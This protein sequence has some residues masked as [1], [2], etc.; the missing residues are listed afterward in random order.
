MTT[1]QDLIADTRRMAYGTLNEQINLVATEYTAGAAT[2]VMDMDV[3]NITPGMILSGGLN[4]WYVK[5]I[6]AGTKTVY[7]IPKFDNSPEA[8]LPV[9]TFVYI[10]PR[11]TDWNLFS[12]INEEILRMSSPENGLYKIASWTANVDSTWQTYSIPSTAQDMI[13]LVRVRYRVPGSDDTWVDIPEKTYRMQMNVDTFYIRLLRNIPSGTDI[14]FIY[15]SPFTPAT[16]VDDDVVADCGLTPSMVDIPPLGA[17]ASLMRTTESRRNQVQMQG[18]A[19]RAQEVVSGANVN[20][21]ARVERDYKTR[22]NEELA[23]L[24]QRNSIQRSL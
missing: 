21:Y 20:M 23:R 2:L 16:S 19:R 17:Y 14:E 13:G 7:V 1:M 24:T 4:V 10:K 22:I 11:V 3:S 9:G 15:K 5:G 18:D 12:T 6:D 8:T